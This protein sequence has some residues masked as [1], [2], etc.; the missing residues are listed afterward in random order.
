MPTSSKT[1]HQN[2]GTRKLSKNSV[3]VRLREQPTGA[4]THDLTVGGIYRLRDRLQFVTPITLRSRSIRPD[5]P[6]DIRAQLPNTHVA[7]VEGDPLD[8][9]EKNT[10]RSDAEALGSLLIELSY[11]A[12]NIVIAD[13]VLEDNQG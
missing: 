12:D 11:T 13:I 4:S 8:V 10:G 3:L 7:W 2:S 9:Y 5:D 1:K 6:E